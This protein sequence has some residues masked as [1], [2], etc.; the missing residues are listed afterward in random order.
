ME[1]INL[2]LGEIITC[3]LMFES[4]TAGHFPP[5]S[6][7]T[8]VRCFAAA[9]ITMRPTLA[10]PAE[11]PTITSWK[12]IKYEQVRYEETINIGGECITTSIYPN[13]TKG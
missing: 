1:T 13:D 3:K 10:L 6:R 8:G 2:A 11:N 7:V 4:T 5:S 9:A 12:N